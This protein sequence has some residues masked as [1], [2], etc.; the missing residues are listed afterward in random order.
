MLEFSPAHL[1]DGQLPSSKGTLF[2]VPSLNVAIL[3]S[4]ILVNTDTVNPMTVN[5]FANFGSGSRR[6]TPTDMI[7]PPGAKYEDSSN[8]TLEA[9]DI[10]EGSCSSAAKVDFSLGG[11][12]TVNT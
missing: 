12:L 7:L 10:L 11:V 5:L 1:A 8:V 6:I 9:G 2:T 4:I 3:K